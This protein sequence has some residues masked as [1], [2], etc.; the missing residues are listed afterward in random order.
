MPGD[1][2]VF[3]SRIP[4]TFDILIHIEPSKLINDK[5]DTLVC[6]RICDLFLLLYFA[7]VYTGSI[8]GSLV[9]FFF[10]TINSKLR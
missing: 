5:R 6:S 1:T 9:N 7:K 10:D 2:I 3:F 4:G 8:R